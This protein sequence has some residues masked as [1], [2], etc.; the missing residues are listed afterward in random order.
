MWLSHRSDTVH[1]VHHELGVHVDP[2]SLDPETARKLQSLDQRSV[3]RHVV[4]RRANLL[5]DL[6]HGDQTARSQQHTN[7]RAAQWVP[8]VA[9]VSVEQV[10]LLVGPLRGLGRRRLT[11]GPG[12]FGLGLSRFGLGLRRVSGSD[13]GVSVSRTR[14]TKSERVSRGRR[15]FAVQA[16][17]AI[18]GVASR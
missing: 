4:S 16:M 13:S 14:R 8:G 15:G 10:A 17:S 1:L 6:S 18:V 11:L 12:R 5:R 2:D 7:R 3:L 9:S